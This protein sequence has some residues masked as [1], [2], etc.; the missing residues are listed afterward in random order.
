[1]ANAPGFRCRDGGPRPRHVR[2]LR[3]GAGECKT[4]PSLELKLEARNRIGGLDGPVVS[5]WRQ[6]TCFIPGSL[7]AG[8]TRGGRTCPWLFDWSI[9]DA[10]YGIDFLGF[11]T[12]WRHRRRRRSSVLYEAQG[13]ASGQGRCRSTAVHRAYGARGSAKTIARNDHK[14]ISLTTILCLR[15]CISAAC[16]A[17]SLRSFSC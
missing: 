3:S 15:S 16:R 12:N 11:C 4:A 6:G 10:T 17:A 14:R 9:R 5:T 1:M 2:S 13:G 7:R 8:Q